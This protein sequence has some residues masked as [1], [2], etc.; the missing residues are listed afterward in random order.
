[1]VQRHIDLD[2]FHVKAASDGSKAEGMRTIP[3]IRKKVIK[4]VTKWIQSTTGRAVYTV[5]LTKKDLRRGNAN[6]SSSI[7]RGIQ[8]AFTKPEEYLHNFLRILSRADPR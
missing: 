4:N 3:Q 6:T 8:A 2:I 5:D 1:M 7:F